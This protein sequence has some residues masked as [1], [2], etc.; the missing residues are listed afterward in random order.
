MDL[1]KKEKEWFESLSELIKKMPRRLELVVDERGCDRE[2][3]EFLSVFYVCL[4]G[5][6]EKTQEESGDLMQ[7][8]PDEIALDRFLANRVCANNH[9][10]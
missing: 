6:A 8:A 3:G 4:R 7:W 9:G 1:T 5:Q 10:Y 2:T